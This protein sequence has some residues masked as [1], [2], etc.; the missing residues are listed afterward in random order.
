MSS[1]DRLAKECKQKAVG[2]EGSSRTGAEDEVKLWKK[3]WQ[4]AIKEKLQHF[5]WKPCHDRISAVVNLKRRII[6]D[7]RCRQCATQAETQEHL[8]F[9]CHKA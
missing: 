1:R 9:H 4:M 8:F 6:A 2:E 5:I 7:D 3:V